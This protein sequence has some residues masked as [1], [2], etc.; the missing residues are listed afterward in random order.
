MF[1]LKEKQCTFSFT[2]KHYVEYDPQY[3]SEF[4]QSHTEQLEIKG[5]GRAIWL[6][7]FYCLAEAS[8]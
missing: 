4:L 6:K 8:F 2:D 3:Y 7:L 5:L 1:L